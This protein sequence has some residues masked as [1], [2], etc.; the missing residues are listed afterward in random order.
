MFNDIAPY[1]LLFIVFIQALRI[2]GLVRYIN[3]QRTTIKKLRSMLTS[4]T[5]LLTEYNRRFR[6][7][8]GLAY[9]QQPI[10]P[11]HRANIVKIRS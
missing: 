3:K 8:D 7:A 2:R 11:T 5:D 9:G 1:V 6:E 4:S 10:G